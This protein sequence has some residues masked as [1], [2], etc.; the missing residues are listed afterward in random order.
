MPNCAGSQTA[1]LMFLHVICESFLGDL[2]LKYWDIPVSNQPL[3]FAAGL[4]GLGIEVAN[5]VDIKQATNKELA[6]RIR[7]DIQSNE[8]YTDLNGFQVRLTVNCLFSKC[9]FEL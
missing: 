3:V 1:G 5:L 7:T 8:F 2:S 4:D 6:M 9:S